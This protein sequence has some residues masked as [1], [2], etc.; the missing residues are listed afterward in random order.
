MAAGM[1]PRDL[2]ERT[3]LFALAVLDLCRRLPKTDEA[4]EAARQLRRAGNSVR[5]NYRAARKGRSRKV[6]EDKL[7]VACEEADE[8][9]DWLEYLRDSGIRHDA[10][11]VDEARQI[12][13]ILTASHK[14]AKRNSARATR[15]P[16]VDPSGEN[17]AADRT[18]QR[19]VSHESQLVGRLSSLYFLLTLNFEV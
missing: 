6:F 16:K 2:R 8:C 12:A 3:R 17:G 15:L 10:R 4:Q 19:Q 7:G 18:A 11:L 9:V 1:P 13:S 5:N 14:T